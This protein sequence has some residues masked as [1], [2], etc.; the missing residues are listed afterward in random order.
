MKPYYSE[1][2]ITIYHGDC[3][4]VLALLPGPGPDCCVTSPPYFGL[5]FYGDSGIGNESSLTQYVENLSACM[6]GVHERLAD[7]GT[8]WLNI[9]DSFANDGK[10]GG[11]TGGKQSHLDDVNRKRVGREKRVT[12]QKPKDLCGVP[13]RIAF[14]LQELG[15]WLRLDIIWHKP[16]VLPESVVDRPTKAH[17]Y[18]FLLSKSQSY[19]YDQE[20]TLEPVSP[21]THMRLSQNLAAQIG[22]ARANGGNKTNGPMKAV[23]RKASIG[24]V[25][26]E[27]HNPSFDAAVCLPVNARNKRSVWT[28]PTGEGLGDHT[29]TFP[30]ALILP[31]VLAGTPPGG[32][33]LDPFCGT[34]TTLAVAKENGCCAIGIEIEERYCEIAA[35][36]MAQEVLAF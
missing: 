34:G 14:A 36:R 16:N 35:R 28:V 12:G 33:V 15:W 13:W 32:T 5:R 23:G 18:I 17:E 3:R 24:T 30:P 1:K 2:G 27:K 4:D 21:N 20:V 29:S 11:E 22:S 10:W 8:L 7:K 31:C 9:G 19:Y 26:I 25:G 6:M